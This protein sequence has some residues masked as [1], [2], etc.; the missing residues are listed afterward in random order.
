MDIQ[1]KLRIKQSEYLEVGALRHYFTKQSLKIFENGDIGFHS[2]IDSSFKN[3]VTETIE[4][5]DPFITSHFSTANIDYHL[6]SERGC[7][8]L[9]SMFSFVNPSWKLI[10]GVFD[11]EMKDNFYPHSWLEKDGVVYDPAMRVVTKKE[12]YEE[13]FI[14]KYSYEKE[15]WITLFQRT[16]M[17][18]YYEED[19]KEGNVN[20]IGKAF[21]YDTIPA[22]QAADQTLE[23][24][25]QFLHQNM[26]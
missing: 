23:Q 17:F 16:G 7:H 10:Q 3:E 26:K 18:T 12:L 13:F 2:N 19:L 21:Y 4:T 20:P 5:L 6:H 11:F 8:F 24:L 15:E 9:A 14:P 22:R 25:R 1:E